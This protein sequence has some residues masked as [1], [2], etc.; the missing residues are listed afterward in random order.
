MSDEDAIT[1]E[2]I[3]EMLMESQFWPPD[4]MRDFQRTQLEQLLR[5]ARANVPFYETRLDCM[6]REDDSI[7]W[8]RWDEIPLLTRQDVQNH[9]KDLLARE[10][11]PGHGD[12]QQGGLDTFFSQ[13]RCS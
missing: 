6:F 13:P 11:P 8:A 2:Q 12:W 1:Y 5:H 7:D 10:L 9:R 4:V 3:L